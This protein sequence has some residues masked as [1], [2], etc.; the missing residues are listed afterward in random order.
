[1]FGDIDLA[2]NVLQAYKQ[3]MAAKSSTSASSATPPMETEIM[4]LTTSYWPTY[5]SIEMK[6]PPEILHQMV[7]FLSPVPLFLSPHTPLPPFPGTVLVLLQ[8]EVP[9]AEA[10]MAALH[11][12]MH[13]NRSVPKREEGVRALIASGIPSCPAPLLL[14]R[15]L[16]PPSQTVVV[17]CFNQMDQ[18]SYQQIRS[19]PSLPPSLLL[20]PLPSLWLRRNETNISDSGELDR[21]LLSLS[22]GKP[23]TRILIKEPKGKDVRPSDTFRFDEN[24]SNKLFRIKI[25]TIQVP[26]L[27]SR[28][29]AYLSPPPP[30]L[31]LK[32]TV[33]EV[34]KTR[35]EVFRDRQYE[36]SSLPLLSSTLSPHTYRL[37]R[38][39]FG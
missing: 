18:L 19:S 12:E 15:H 37:M 34:E 33:E 22:C 25:N 13:R 31:Q 26:L 14:R 6:I 35:E 27:L 30:P 11:R 7:C 16:P 17:M 28:P 9:G 39:L 1:M 20:T 3:A 5:P 24:Y 36:V 10:D 21:T 38:S 23:G 8:R 4:V 29:P 32:E 2:R